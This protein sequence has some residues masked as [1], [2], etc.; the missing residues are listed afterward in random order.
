MSKQNLPMTKEQRE[1][2]AKIYTRMIDQLCNEAETVVN[3]HARVDYTDR[4]D[5]TFNTKVKGDASATA[6]L[7]T[8]IQV[9]VEGVADIASREDEYTERRVRELEQQAATQ[10]QRFRDKMKT[11]Q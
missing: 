11:Y 2:L 7:A 1:R 4:D 5:V 6:L 10:A 9:L 3:R 8:R